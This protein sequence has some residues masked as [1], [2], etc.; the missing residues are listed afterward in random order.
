MFYVTFLFLCTS[1]YHISCTYIFTNKN[2]ILSLLQCVP[3]SPRCVKIIIQNSLL[4]I[5]TVCVCVDKCCEM[6]LSNQ[7]KTDKEVSSASCSRAT[8][9]I[10]IYQLWKKNWRG[11]EI[12]AS[13]WNVRKLEMNTN[14]HNK[15]IFAKFLLKSTD[16]YHF[17]KKIIW[18][19]YLNYT[20]WTPKQR[21]QFD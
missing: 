13:W 19:V 10:I 1:P 4:Q 12:Q 17:K 6:F 8:R 21:I 2:S 20:D 5:E 9:N 18:R 15:S 11:V 7:Q 16:Y 14:H 3:S